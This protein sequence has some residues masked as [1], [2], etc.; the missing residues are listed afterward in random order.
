MCLRCLLSVSASAIWIGLIFV[1]VELK[2]VG[3]SSLCLGT[4]P[5]LTSLAVATIQ[6]HTMDLKCVLLPSYATLRTVDSLCFCSPRLPEAH[7]GIA[8]SFGGLLCLRSYSKGD[9]VATRLHAGD[10]QSDKLACWLL[11]TVAVWHH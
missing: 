8:H 2:Q 10:I 5:H 7:V 9:V 3:L 4:C 11:S 1:Q 6:L